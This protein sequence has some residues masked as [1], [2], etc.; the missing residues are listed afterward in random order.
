MSSDFFYNSPT[1]EVVVGAKG[2]AR[3]FYL[4]KTLL[5]NHSEYFATCLRS[6]FIEGKIGAVTLDEDDPT[7]FDAFA[8]WLYAREYEITK[9][10]GADEKELQVAWYMLHAR[11]YALGNKLVADDFKRDIVKK[12]ARRL[13]N[14]DYDDIPMSLVIDMARVIYDGTSD[15][16]G[17]EMRE[18]IAAYCASRTGNVPR[19]DFEIN[20]FFSA[21]E[22]KELT[23]CQQADFLADVWILCKP[24]PRLKNASLPSQSASTVLRHFIISSSARLAKRSLLKE[25]PKV[26]LDVSWEGPV[27]DA[28]DEPTLTV[29]GEFYSCSCTTWLCQSQKHFHSNRLFWPRNSLP[30]R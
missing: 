4:H 10:K 11:A 23:D 24:T 8:H 13:E 21:S 5:M 2:E 29:K 1:V 17:C 6:N 16:D 26:Y 27:L 19:G 15:K 20:R 22:M 30:L 28:N 7:A 14:E 18:L 3:T 9:A 12:T 25:H